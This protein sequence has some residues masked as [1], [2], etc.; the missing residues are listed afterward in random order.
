MSNLI[1]SD[2]FL[3]NLGPSGI[4]LKG[5][6]RHILHSSLS[7]RSQMGKAFSTGALWSFSGFLELSLPSASGKKGISGVYTKAVKPCTNFKIVIQ[8][9]Y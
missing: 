2:A 9:L 1:E 3:Y 8:Q 7:K 4:R 6:P 5:N